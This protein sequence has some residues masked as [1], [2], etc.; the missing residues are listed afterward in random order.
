MVCVAVHFPQDRIFSCDEFL[1]PVASRQMT[2]FKHVFTLQSTTSPFGTDVEKPDQCL[3]CLPSLQ[4]E[5][6]ETRAAREC[7]YILQHIVH[8]VS[9]C[10]LS[11]R[12]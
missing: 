3:V 1:I 6:D 5:V 4:L 8:L 11:G 9:V 10:R 2:T 12:A 7:G